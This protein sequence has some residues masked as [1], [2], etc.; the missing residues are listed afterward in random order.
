M[1]ERLKTTFENLKKNHK[2]FV[3]LDNK[4]KILISCP[5]A[6]EQ[7]RN[8]NIKFSEPET[9]LLGLYLNELGYPCF[10]KTSN[11]NDDANSDFD[12][13][14]KQTLVNYCKENNIQFVIDLHQ[15]RRDR[16]MSICLGTG[17]DKNKNLCK[18]DYI[19]Q[20]FLKI[21]KKNNYITTINN[22]FAAS[23]NT[24]VSGYLSSNNISALQMEINSGIVDKN[25]DFEKLATAL[26]DI[27]M[28]IKKEFLKIKILLVSNK[29]LNYEKFKKQNKLLFETAQNLNIHLDLKNNT[30]LI[31]SLYNKQNNF[32]YYNAVLFYDKDVFLCKK[33]ENLGFNVF[34]SSECIKNCDN[35]VLTYQILEQNNIPIP[36]TFILPLI[37]YYKKEF[38]SQWVDCIVNELTFPLIAKKWFGSEGQQVF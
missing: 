14:Y 21:L 32:P 16:E 29:S 20:P 37:F 9:A 35:K 10:I 18:K 13:K 19:L 30:D 22:P 36:K 31:F 33:L 6:V 8:G 2:N 15:L 7:T 27:V 5:H 26:K 4:E 38:I 25:E 17:D 1:K 28:E 23:K 24:T 12:C 11:E 34:N 3:C